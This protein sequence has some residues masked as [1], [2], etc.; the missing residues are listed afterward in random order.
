M[1]K[2][3][4]QI[5]VALGLVTLVT[6]LT[7]IFLL[8]ISLDMRHMS[9][10]GLMLGFGAA[11][12]AGTRS[13]M[14]PAVYSVVS[15][16]PF[17]VFLKLVILSDLPS[18]WFVAPLM[19]LVSL[20]GFMAARFQRK[21]RRA[22]TMVGLLVS[23]LFSWLYIPTLIS[24]DLT[25]TANDTTS[26]FD[27]M[28][29]DGSLISSEAL[30]G[31]VVVLDF[32]GTWCKPCIAELP[33]LAR[34]RE[35]FSGSNEV[36]FFIVNSD[37]GGDTPEKAERF[38]KRYGNGFSFGYDHGRKTYKAIGLTGAGVPSLVI[39]DKQGNVRLRHIGYNKA[40]TD[41][42]ENMI[43]AVDRVLEDD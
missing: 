6:L 8:T 4:K 33:E 31:R 12:W 11:C 10:W 25:R 38:I 26:A 21:V 20:F 2:N 13:Y 19:L 43:A 36:S 1:N 23:M 17:I 40:E 7:G 42:V 28:A 18:M 9:L 15:L 14:S 16:L 5:L 29:T 27:F 34:V 37:Q 35:H 41:F 39:L 3:L 24:D 30:K 32:Y 22:G